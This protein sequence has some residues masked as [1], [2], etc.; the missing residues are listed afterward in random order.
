M[1]VDKLTNVSRLYFKVR[2]VYA[3]GAECIPQIP[4]HTGYI[5]TCKQYIVDG[6]KQR[7]FAVYKHF[8]KLMNTMLDKI[9][10]PLE[11]DTKLFP[12]LKHPSTCKLTLLVLMCL[13]KEC[14]FDP[15]C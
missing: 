4:H 12:S 13:C 14:P 1:H 5:E 2:Y 8:V 9:R 6:H 10:L 3:D 15:F 7:S 11:R